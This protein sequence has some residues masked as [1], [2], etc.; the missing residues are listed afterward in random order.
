MTVKIPIHK[1]NSRPRVAQYLRNRGIDL[2][3]PYLA[4]QKGTFFEITQ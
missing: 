4:K 2:N 1:M 3:R